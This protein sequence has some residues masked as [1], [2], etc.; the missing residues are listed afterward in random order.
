MRHAVS[1]SSRDLRCSKQLTPAISKLRCVI[2]SEAK[3]LQLLAAPPNRVPHPE[4]SEGWDTTYTHPQGMPPMTAISDPRI[5]AG[6]PWPPGPSFVRR[7]LT[8]QIFRH[9]TI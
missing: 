9:S 3:D 6:S 7:A 4:R 1:N 8:G 2:L 5:P